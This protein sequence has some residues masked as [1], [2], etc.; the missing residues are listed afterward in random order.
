MLVLA[1]ATGKEISV[2]KKDVKERRESKTS[3]M[4]DNFSDGIPRED[5][6]NLIGFLLAKGNRPAAGRITEP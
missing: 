5:F 2:A 3:L 1:D 6:N 4:P